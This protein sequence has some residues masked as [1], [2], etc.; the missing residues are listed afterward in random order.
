MHLIK[1][2]STTSKCPT[3]KPLEQHENCLFRKIFF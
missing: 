1:E 3:K 2:V